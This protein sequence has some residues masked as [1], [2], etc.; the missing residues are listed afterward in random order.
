MITDPLAGRCS[1]ASVSNPVGE[2]NFF[3][4][5]IEK[6][7]LSS[8]QQFSHIIYNLK[9]LRIREKQPGIH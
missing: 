9:F 6:T 7:F 2:P 3:I 1:D 4:F 8:F 5:L